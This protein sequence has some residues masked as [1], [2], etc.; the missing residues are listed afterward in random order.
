MSGVKHSTVQPRLQPN[1]AEVL[2]NLFW[3]DAKKHVEHH[4]NFKNIRE[5]GKHIFDR[6]PET[7]AFPLT[8]LHV[9][10]HLSGEYRVS[11]IPLCENDTVV[12]GGL[13]VDLYG[14]TP[15]TSLDIITLRERVAE[16]PFPMYVGSSKSAGLH[17]YIFCDGPVAASTLRKTLQAV[18]RTLGLRATGKDR[19]TEVYP[20]QDTI[21][22]VDE[23]G[24]NKEGNAMELP[25]CGMKYDGSLDTGIF[26]LGSISSSDSLEDFLRRVQK[27]SVAAIKNYTTI[28]DTDGSTGP[29]R[30]SNTLV[31]K[32]TNET[33][34]LL[35]EQHP[36]DRS[37]AC[38]DIITEMIN[39]GFSDDEITLLLRDYPNG[40]ASHY[41]EHNSSLAKDIQRIRQKYKRNRFVWPEGTLW[42]KERKP[43]QNVHNVILALR[44][45]DLGGLFTFD[46]MER[47]VKVTEFLPDVF[48]DQEPRKKKFPYPFRD[49]DCTHMQAWF[50]TVG[51]K[52]ATQ[53]TIGS[54]IY[55]V[56]KERSYHPIK[57]YLDLLKW[58]GRRRLNTWLSRALG[59]PSNRYHAKVSRKFLLS[60]I[61]RIYRPGCKV[62][63]TLVLVGK[64]GKLKSTIFSVL[65]GKWFS[66]DLPNL[67]NEKD[68]ALHLN[69]K[70]LVEMA[71]L[72]AIRKQ[73]EEHVKAFLTRQIDKYR[74]PYGHVEVDEPRQ[75][76]FG[77]TTNRADFLHDETGSRRFWPVKVV[78][79]DLN[80]LK[81]NRDQLFAEAKVCFDK[82]EKWWPS[83]EWEEKHAKE[84]QDKYQQT[85]DVWEAAIK[86]YVEGYVEEY[87]ENKIRVGR[88]CMR[89]LGFKEMR[90]IDPR[91]VGRVQKILMKLGMEKDRDK[92]STYWYFPFR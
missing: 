37:R 87:R 32:L 15:D 2:F 72:S 29:P 60:M 19:N 65:A 49:E 47:Q 4:G 91:T 3:S 34:K 44:S 27:V 10:A 88:I 45:P 70:W 73:D 16:L 7:I 52:T 40:P 92:E 18:A 51:M 14:A 6:S 11:G 77:A 1:D 58:D 85:D 61:A 36:G 31:N 9:Q 75:C 79:I 5:D 42:N 46:E 12:W 28:R 25:Y 33:R 56:A 63:Y 86:E 22:G 55:F 48:D 82:G 24:R 50:Q 43:H 68:A 39:R 26:G 76:V 64:Q 54:G 53:Q 20:K 41:R 57:Q 13:D 17:I 59:V 81:A 62:D 89:V 30:D 83:D 8:A 80:W 23:H 74:P 90:D 35:N 84:E 69:G 66:D 21:A 71:E 67:R 78:A 38:W